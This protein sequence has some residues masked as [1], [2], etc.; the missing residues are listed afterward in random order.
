MLYASVRI[1]RNDTTMML[2]SWL[3]WSRIR[4]MM[5][6]LSQPSCCLKEADLD[7]DLDRD[8]VVVDVDADV[9]GRRR[10]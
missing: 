2:V 1:E 6:V 9:D 3:N 4:V 8:D 10:R 7:L 5:T